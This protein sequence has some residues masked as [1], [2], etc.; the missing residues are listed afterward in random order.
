MSGS[1]SSQTALVVSPQVGGLALHAWGRTTVLDCATALS[2]SREHPLDDRPELLLW[3]Y[4]GQHQLRPTAVNYAALRAA[5][6]VS[7]HQLRISGAVITAAAEDATDEVQF[8][9]AKV[10]AADRAKQLRM[11][12]TA[13]LAIRGVAADALRNG[14]RSGYERYRAAYSGRELAPPSKAYLR[15]MANRNRKPTTRFSAKLDRRVQNFEIASHPEHPSRLLLKFRIRGLEHAVELPLPA[16]TY[17]GDWVQGEYLPGEVCTHAG[18]LWI[19]HAKTDAEPGTSDAWSN[20]DPDDAA[21]H[22][23]YIDAWLQGIAT[24][25]NQVC[26]QVSESVDSALR[27]LHQRLRDGTLTAY[28]ERLRPDQ[29]ATLRDIIQSGPTL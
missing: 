7:R 18:G 4:A 29:L 8:R 19:A 11:R 13:Y 16:P 10:T 23:A 20:Y 27:S 9:T 22:S 25:L 17:V 21:P 2:F 12:K 1:V 15:I 26:A 3:Y 24:G 5:A 6:H 28:L 14:I